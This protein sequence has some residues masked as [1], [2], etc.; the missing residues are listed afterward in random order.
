MFPPLSLNSVP[1]PHW[2][3][4]MAGVKMMVPAAHHVKA[5]VLDNFPC[6]LI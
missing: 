3:E 5:F 1:N 4:G 2:K 6:K